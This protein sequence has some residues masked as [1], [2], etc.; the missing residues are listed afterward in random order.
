M[1][2]K[3]SG[4]A[5][6]PPSAAGGA[7][8]SGSP[9]P[10][11]HG[12]SRSSTPP[13]FATHVGTQPQPSASSGSGLQYHL[14]V[15]VDRDTVPHKMVVQVAD[16]NELADRLQTLSP[17]QP[18]ATVEY[19]DDDF[20][21][22]V[23][24]RSLEP[25]KQLGCKAKLH[26]STGGVK[27]VQVVEEN[28]PLE[29]AALREQVDKLGPP[30]DGYVYELAQAHRIVHPGLEQAFQN[31]RRKLLDP[32]VRTVMLFYTNNAR[33]SDQVVQHGFALPTGQ[34]AM[35]YDGGIVFASDID[36]Q[37]TVTTN[38]KFLLC[39]VAVG[40]SLTVQAGD[41]RTV[42]DHNNYDSL[43]NLTRRFGGQQRLEE[44]VVF[45]P[46][47]AIPRYVVTC[48]AVR[49][50]MRRSWN[51]AAL[52]CDQHPGESLKLW[53][54]DCRRLMCPYC[55]TIGSH[56]G[57]T[58]RDI[59][60]VAVFEKQVVTKMFHTLDANLR[61][62]QSE[63]AE[64]E[65]VRGLHANIARKGEEEIRQVIR[66]LHQLLVNEEQHLIVELGKRKDNGSQQLDRQQEVIQDVTAE[67][68]KKFTQLK[69]FLDIPVESSQ[70]ARMEFLSRLQGVIDMLQT[71]P[72][73]DDPSTLN[74]K[75]LPPLHTAVSYD[76]AKAGIQSLCLAAGDGK[77]GQGSKL[78]ASVPRA[79]L[80][81]EVGKVHDLEAGY[82]WVIPNATQHFHL[83]QSRDIFSDV[84][85]LLGCTWEL[86]ITPQPAE[87]ISVF[88][89]A[90]NHVHRMDFKVT[91][92]STK[93]WYQRAAKNWVEGF[94]GRGWGIK[95]YAEIKELQSTYI[96]N[97]A[98]KI[99]VTP[100]SGLY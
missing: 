81:A 90:A 43:L 36:A 14:L 44:W 11:M 83:H 74:I 24:M 97:D 72:T 100:T 41:R 45:R 35:H 19:W 84:F 67:L 31:R 1:S 50:H 55:M 65:R 95:P 40:R 79:A 33:P 78:G 69:Q 42:F 26:V 56:K 21:Q 57:H 15:T 22:F 91:M 28:D 71:K 47:Q 54:V 75:E 98:L 32:T 53:C 85:S 2:G 94:R 13:Q 10:S 87:H 66:D 37:P 68:Q 99:V 96:D 82:I 6:I 73:Y 52:G 80:S 89:H 4:L 46:D 18:I 23:P 58:A 61:R 64:I 29:W 12:D 5:G 59:A 38:L 8:A 92:F 62:R 93:G 86:R 3:S 88:L 63:I 30:K 49:G 70:Q 39:E 27:M 76:E 17:G 77:E 25:I 34:A 51:P 20:G 9:T 48:A 16:I 7:R 60:E